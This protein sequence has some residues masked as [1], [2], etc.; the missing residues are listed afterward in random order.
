MPGRLI[1]LPPFPNC[2]GFLAKFDAVSEC[3]VRAGYL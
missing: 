2:C 3:K 1:T